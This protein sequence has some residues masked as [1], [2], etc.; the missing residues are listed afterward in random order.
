MKT[1][2]RTQA[3]LLGAT[4]LGMILFAG[5]TASAAVIAQTVNQTGADANGWASAIWGT[6]AAVATGANDYVTPAT[7]AVRTPNNT[8]PAAFAGNSLMITNSIYFLKH[9][10]GVANANVVLSA[11]T[12]TYHG[13]PGGTNVPIGGTLQVLTDPIKPTSTVTSDQGTATRDIWIQS[14]MSGTGN[15]TVNMT[16]VTNA[17]ILSGTNTAFSGNWTNTSGFITIGSGTTNALGSGAVTLTGN[18]TTALIF[19]STNNFVINNPISGPGFMVKLNTNTVIINGN[20]TFTGSVRI[21]NGVIQLGAS[22]SF[23]NASAI[24]LG[25]G[26]LDASLAGGLTLGANQSMN[27]NGKVI[28]NLLVP[29][30]NALNFNLSSTTNDILNVTGTLTLNGN[31]NLN[32]A[33]AGFKP[34]GAYR[35][36]NYTGTIQG[37]GSFTLVPP[38]GS[39]EAFALDTST[40]GQVNLIVTGSLLNLTWVGDGSANNWDTTT[41]NWTGDATVFSAGNNVTFTDSG[42]SVPSI[43]IASSSL[44]PSSMTVSNTTG[45]YVFNGATSAT[46][47]VTT[48]TLTKMGTNELDFTSSGNNFSGP[49]IIQS[50]IL[51]IGVGGSFG[52]LG[53]GPITNNGIL[54]VNLTA[55]GVALNA[56]ISGTGSL[57][58]TG[59]GAAV[60]VGGSNSYTGPTTIGD[61]CQLSVSTSSALGSTN[62]GTTV[63][64]NGRLGV[65]TFVGTMTV[66]EPLLINGT[67]IAGAPGA[68]YVNTTGNNVTWAGPVT[69]GSDSRIR[70][71]NPNVLMNFANTVLGTNV[72][73]E[74]TAGNATTTTDTNTVMTFQNTLSLGSA[75]SLTADGLGV[76]VLAGSSNLCGNTIVNAGTLLVNGLLD[77]VSVSVNSTAIL[78]GL[79]TI[80]GPVTVQSGGN[81]APGTSGIGT[82]TISNSLALSGTATM[83]INRTNAQNADLVVAAS[84]AYGGTLTVNNIGDPLQAGDTFILFNGTISSTFAVTNLPA[85]SSTNLY[86]DTSLLNNGT[87]KV[88]A[89]TASVPTITSPLVSGTNFTLQVTASQSGFNYVLQAT[90]T[91]APTAWTGVQ[92]NAGTG[93]TLSFTIPITL[94]N[95]QQFFRISVQ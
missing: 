95:P 71:V 51:S 13:G 20:N 84:V 57:Q 68:L 63:L 66:A 33:L 44:F 89:N 64:A 30:T 49:I 41:A 24:T 72:A 4:I 5:T 50:G 55:N 14:T 40:P 15:M 10:N 81:L 85:L 83:E 80:L 28:G 54:Q 93:G 39:N 19:N 59:G 91:L 77:T 61:G 46:G 35:L 12:I 1:N 86:W 23:T 82:L 18:G 37:G 25:G 45:Q 90:P 87:I 74:C 73:L 76:V 2:I 58:I 65:T 92:T 3:V 38:V 7:F 31:P 21:T 79:G 48:G 52:S 67:G 53:T 69:I 17:L 6:P 42:S 56:P 26:T 60:V 78:G 94:G 62:V 34:S 75:G 47:I 43:T 29:T 22:S 36:I 27:C 88:A 8:T 16:T 11:G 70:A 32:L 9:N